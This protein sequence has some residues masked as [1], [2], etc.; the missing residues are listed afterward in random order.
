MIIIYNSKQFC[1]ALILSMKNIFHKKAHI[2]ILNILICQVTFFF[3]ELWTSAWK[4]LYKLI[5]ESPHEH[6]SSLYVP[7]TLPCKFPPAPCSVLSNML[8]RSISQYFAAFAHSKRYISVTFFYQI[9]SNIFNDIYIH[10]GLWRS[11]V[12]FLLLFIAS[13]V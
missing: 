3:I 12:Q 13:A 9:Y 4:P 5:L 6:P 11:S 10:I 2:V 7:H 8:H 1:N